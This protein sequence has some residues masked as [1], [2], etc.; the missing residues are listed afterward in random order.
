[1]ME[2]KLRDFKNIKTHSKTL[3]EKDLFYIYFMISLAKHSCSFY[4][5]YISEWEEKGDMSFFVSIIFIFFIPKKVTK[6]YFI[7]H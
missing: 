2:I 6:Q 4:L 1:M 5:L 7:I 3:L